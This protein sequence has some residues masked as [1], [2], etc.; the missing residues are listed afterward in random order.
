MFKSLY[1][2]CIQDIKMIKYQHPYAKFARK[3]DK[4]YQHFV[5]KTERFEQSKIN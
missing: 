4:L 2:D 3:D 1:S 5:K